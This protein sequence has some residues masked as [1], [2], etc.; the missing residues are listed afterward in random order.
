[1]IITDFKINYVS[2]NVL[3]RV[4]RSLPVPYDS[5]KM[6]SLDAQFFSLVFPIWVIEQ[7][8]RRS[9]CPTNRFIHSKRP[10]RL[11]CSQKAAEPLSIKYFTLGETYMG[12][13]RGRP[14][15]YQANSRY[16]ILLEL[17]FCM[18]P[19]L[20]INFQCLLIKPNLI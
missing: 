8:G 7:K 4:Q 2:F 19:E 6:S 10:K 13:K 16:L 17:N 12:Q 14:K 15:I 3:T 1:M 9:Y 18:P 5:S 20:I 11:I